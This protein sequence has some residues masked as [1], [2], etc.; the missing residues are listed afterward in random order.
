M[1]FYCTH[2]PYA[3][4]ISRQG[5]YDLDDNFHNSL[6]W[7]SKSTQV[8]SNCKHPQPIPNPGLKTKTSRYSLDTTLKQYCRALLFLM[9]EKKIRK[10]KP[11]RFYK[12]PYRSFYTGAAP[13]GS[14][15]GELYSAYTISP[16]PFNFSIGIS[17]LL[18]PKID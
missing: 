10:K 2:T 7:T 11:E 9:N 13:P 17:R 4:V 6:V 8:S 12:R 18:M 16:P 15:P 1:L 3:S 14:V 5:R